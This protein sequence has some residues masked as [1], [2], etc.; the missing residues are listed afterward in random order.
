MGLVGG[1]AR[2]VQN[3]PITFWKARAGHAGGAI[4]PLLAAPKP[5]LFIGIKPG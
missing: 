4:A 3:Q 5:T 2:A 1:D